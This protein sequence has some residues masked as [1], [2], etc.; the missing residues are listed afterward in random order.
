MKTMFR[1]KRL[2]STVENG[3]SEEG[4]EEVVER[5]READAC[6]LYLIQQAVD[7]K[8]LI[9]ITEALTAKQAWDI[10]QTEFQGGSKILS[11]KLYSLKSELETLRMKNGEKVQDYITRV[12]DIVYQLRVLGESMEETAV[13][14]KILRS[15]NPTF[16]HVVSS[17]V[18][19]KDLGKLTVEELSSSLKGHETILMLSAGEEETTLQAM[20]SEFGETNVRGG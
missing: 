12:L 4:E 1:S 15:L 10:L 16:K 13:V 20:I 14:G 7:E 9:R 11:V 6:A 5:R 19:A 17:I 8:I 2:W 18:E 3:F